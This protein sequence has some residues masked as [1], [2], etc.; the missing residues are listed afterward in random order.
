LSGEDFYDAFIRIP[1]TFLII[2]AVNGW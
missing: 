1:E 2:P